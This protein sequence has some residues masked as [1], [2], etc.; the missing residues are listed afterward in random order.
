MSHSYDAMEFSEEE[1]EQ[2]LEFID[3]SLLLHEDEHDRRAKIHQ[4]GVLGNILSSE[5]YV[6]AR[7][8]FPNGTTTIMC[9]STK[10]EAIVRIVEVKNEVGE[11]GSDP[12]MQAECD[13]VLICSSK[14]VVLSPFIDL[15]ES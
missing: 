4:V 11:G 6:D 2:S 7:S 9:H 3:I 8:I 1:L 13:F 14:K 15:I 10:Q 12:I 5:V